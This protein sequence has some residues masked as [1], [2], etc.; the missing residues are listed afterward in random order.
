[1]EDPKAVPEIK[2]LLK[3][4]DERVAE[5][6]SSQDILPSG[7]SSAVRI[8]AYMRFRNAIGECRSLVIVIQ[9][10]LG[11]APASFVA[12]AVQQLDKATMAIFAAML[13]GNLKYLTF[14]SEH[15]D[16]PLGSRSIL[17]EELR[18]LHEAHLVL[19]GD[20]YR[21]IVPADMEARVEKAERIL[22]EI[23]ER[24]P[25]LLVVEEED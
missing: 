17:M 12:E 11:R 16:L 9:G 7:A 15:E 2:R 14:L 1:M 4:L 13:T 8:D 22:A 23:I 10:K 19:T 24:A 21:G 20:K 18:A 5:L 25:S 6:P 3:T